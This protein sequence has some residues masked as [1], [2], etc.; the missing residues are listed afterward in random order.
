MCMVHTDNN[1]YIDKELLRQNQSYDNFARFRFRKQRG[2]L[3]ILNIPHSLYKFLD[4]SWLFMYF[5]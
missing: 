3:V 4:L 5:W 2:F 1:H